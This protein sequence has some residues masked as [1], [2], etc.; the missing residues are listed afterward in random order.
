MQV[1]TSQSLQNC[2]TEMSSHFVRGIGR[3]CR[4]IRGVCS[5]ILYAEN[6]NLSLPFS[7]GL[8]LQAKA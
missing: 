2:V 8:L 7:I 5:M 3:L 1:I 4:Y 6:K